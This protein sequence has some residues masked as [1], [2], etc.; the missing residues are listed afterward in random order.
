MGTFGI[1]MVNWGMERVGEQWKRHLV[2]WG[3]CEVWEK[4]VTRETPRKPHDD[5]S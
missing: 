4:P 5:P 2:K 3:H 1:R